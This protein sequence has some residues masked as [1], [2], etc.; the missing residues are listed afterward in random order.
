MFQKALSD[1]LILNIFNVCTI[2]IRNL[3]FLF[4]VFKQ[5]ILSRKKI[6]RFL[7]SLKTYQGKWQ[8]IF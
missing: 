2:I 3:S 8:S 7:E 5:I 1:W 6:L 4:G